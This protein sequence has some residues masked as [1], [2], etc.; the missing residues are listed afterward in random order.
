MVVMPTPPAANSRWCS[1]M[2]RVG[3]PA[4]DM[5]SLAPALMKRLG[6]VIGPTCIGS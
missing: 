5:F 3:M 6:S 2:A 4:M 1:S